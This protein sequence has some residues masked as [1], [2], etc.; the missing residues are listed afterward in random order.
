MIPD[1]ARRAADA[2]ELMDD[3]AADR[4]ALERTYALFPL[5]NAVVAGWR[6]AYRRQIR[7][8]ASRGHLRVLD[9]GCGGGDVTRDIAR[10]LRR[11]GCAADVTG[12]D[13]DGRAIRWASE[14]RRPRREEVRWLRASTSDLVRQGERF[15]VVLSNHL[16]HHLSDTELRS[17]LDDSL[18][19][20]APGGVVV[21]SDIARSRWA[22]ALFAAAT[23]PVARP[24]S[25]SFIRPDGLTSIRR[26]YTATELRR[27]AGAPW[28]VERRMP[29]RLLLTARE[30][31]APR[32]AP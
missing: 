3:P 30:P 12:L 14:R 2:Q 15:D 10:R 18:H 26:S 4:R 17:V 5:V 7:P 20:L 9:I 16:L 21:H 23:V 8:L 29:F 25:R 13:V 28:T 19:L 32:S 31:A 22:Y 27:A 1:L 11:D 24:V 6:G